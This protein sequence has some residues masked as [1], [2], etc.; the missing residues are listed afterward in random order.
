MP[1]PSD[2][3][4]LSDFWL[5]ITR[6]E[7]P[8]R[9][10]GK[11]MLHTRDPH[12]L[13]QILRGE[14]LS[15][16][17]EDASSIKTTAESAKGAKAGAVYLYCAPYT[18]QELV[19]R[20]ADELRELDRKHQFQLTGPLLYKTDLHNTWAETLARPGDGYYELLKRNWLYRYQGG[21]L[22]VN[23]VIQAL[24]QALEDPPDNADPEFLIIR[25]LLERELFA[26]KESKQ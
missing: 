15:G 18:D 20:L 26:G 13:F 12:G 2:F 6:V 21:K 1:D 23:P 24:H 16:S 8:S 11:W 10:F 4:E 5:S 25:S 7:H 9:G 22:I 17:L 3:S 14:L 19:L